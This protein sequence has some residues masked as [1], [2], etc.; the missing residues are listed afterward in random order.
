MTE[1]G[2]GAVAVAVAVALAKEYLAAAVTSKDQLRRLLESERDYS[3][4]INDD[5][6]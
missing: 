2:A 5:D 1:A 3:K 6:D 4:G